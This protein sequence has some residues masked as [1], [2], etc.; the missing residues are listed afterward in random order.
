MYIQSKTFLKDNVT[1]V[2]PKKTLFLTLIVFLGFFMKILGQENYKNE[3]GKLE[4][5]KAAYNDAYSKMDKIFSLKGIQLTKCDIFIRA[6]KQEKKLEV[7]AKN[8][9]DDSFVKVVTY[10]F[11]VLSGELG[12]KRKQ[13][14]NQVPEGVYYIDRFNP[15][16]NFY[17]SLGVNYPNDYDKAVATKGNP[18]GDIFIH[19]NCV[20]IGCIP[21]TDELIKELYVVCLEA[22]SSGQSKIPVH[23]F[24]FRMHS[25]L[26]TMI[27]SSELKSYEKHI[28]F[29]KML[30][31]I[32]E[33]FENN[34]KLPVVK[35]SK[36]GYFIDN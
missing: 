16:S 19:G 30:V 7:F 20:S 24:P 4:R 14:D 10:D 9:T 1:I 36:T 31:P 26:S 17:L 28:S 34:H 2:E 6:F 29:W 11:C 18:G 21:I 23:I 15:W 22:Q 12:P 32:Y 3:Q 13:G 35:I 27:F 25:F 5:V 33:H 8:K